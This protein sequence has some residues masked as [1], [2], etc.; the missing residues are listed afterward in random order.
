VRLGGDE[1]WLAVPSGYCEPMGRYANLAALTDA[2]DS[3]SVTYLALVDCADQA[4][5]R[6]ISRSLLLRAPKSA[7]SERV[8]RAEFLDRLG[9]L[10]PTPAAERPR[11]G[12]L[13]L[14][15]GD[16][17]GRYLGGLIRQGRRTTALAVAVTAVKGHVVSLSSYVTGEPEQALEAALGIAQAQA[18]ALVEAN[19]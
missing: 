10:A 8:T 11:D 15:A 19:P 13:R 4:A 9:T 18:R 16:E 2:S 14:V 7:M 5:G 3:Q 17:N 12:A 6:A 1:V